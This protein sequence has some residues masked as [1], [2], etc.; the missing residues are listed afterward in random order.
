VC[1]RR[2]ALSTCDTASPA[3]TPAAGTPLWCC[4]QTVATIVKH[5]R[6]T[7]ARSG[8]IARLHAGVRV[9]R[10]DR[11]VQRI[12]TDEGSTV[13]YGKLAPLGRYAREEAG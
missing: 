12:F 7:L 1:L 5:R 6:L 4:R 10:V 13:G 11:F 9:V 8:S 3:D 2:L